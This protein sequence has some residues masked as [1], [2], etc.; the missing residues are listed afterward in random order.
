MKLSSADKAKNKRLYNTYGL[1]LSEWSTMLLCQNEVCQICK[2]MPKSGIL[3]VDH[4]HIKGFKTMTPE[5][6]RPYIRALL[7]FMCNTSLKSFEK[8]TD[9][10]RNRRHLEGVYEYFQKYHLKGE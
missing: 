10:Q 2:T 4:I 1:T 7:C 8:T 3:C 9:G 5:Q 6:K